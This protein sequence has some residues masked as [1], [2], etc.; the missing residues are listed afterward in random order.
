[1]ETT[2]GMT[3]LGGFMMGTRTGDMDPGVLLY[4]VRECGYDDKTLEQ[5][6]DKESGLK[7]VSGQ[8]AD[9]E[10]LLELRTGGHQAAAQAVEMFCY[11]ARKT[12]GSLAAVLGGLDLLVFTGG[13]GENAVVVRDMICRGLEHLGIE[14]DPAKNE[15]SAETISAEGGRCRVGVV[16]TNEDLMIARHTYALVF[17]RARRAGASRAAVPGAAPQRVGGRTGDPRGS[18]SLTRSAEGGPS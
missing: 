6:L 9:M 5:L 12:I 11:Q 15:A 2:M 1:L 18:S 8:T 14:L 7:G 13:I 3:P 10:T 4:L 17:G 16:H